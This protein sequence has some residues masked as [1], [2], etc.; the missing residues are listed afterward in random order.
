MIDSNTM[1]N[2]VMVSVLAF[3]SC[4]CSITVDFWHMS[5]KWS[6]I[7]LRAGEMSNHL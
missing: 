6:V 3:D 2:V 5:S 1:L 4:L 7:T